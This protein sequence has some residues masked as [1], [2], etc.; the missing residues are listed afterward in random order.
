MSDDNH[1]FNPVRPISNL[2]DD[3]L[4][5]RGFAEAISKSLLGWTG[6]DSLVLAICGRW[7][8]GKTSVKNMVL[9][10]IPADASRKPEV[11][12]FN[13]WQWAGQDQVFD[14]FFAAVEDGLRRA[15]P[16][17]V[18]KKR[19]R[20]WNSRA[21]FYRAVRG[22]SVGVR[23]ILLAILSLILFAAAVVSSFVPEA[24]NVATW[25]FRIGSFIFAPIIF[26]ERILSGLADIAENLHKGWGPKVRSVFERRD[27]KKQ[28]LA[29]SLSNLERPILVVIDDIDR[30]T[31]EQIRMVF[32]LVKANADF[33]SLI[34]LLLFQRDIVEKSLREDG[35]VSG[36][37]YLEKIAQVLIDLPMI[38]RARVE[39]IL[40]KRLDVV[41]GFPEAQKRFD[42]L[43][44][45]DMFLSGVRPYFRNLRDVY[46]FLSTL[47]FHLSVFRREGRLDINVLDLVGVEVLRLFEPSVY[48]LMA[49]SKAT[50]TS[51]HEDIMMTVDSKKYDEAV[52]E[53][54]IESATKGHEDDV[55]GLLRVL[56][57][58]CEPIATL[59]ASIDDEWAR[60]LRVAHPDI[61]DRYFLFAIPAGDVSEDEVGGLL[62]KVS[63]RNEFVTEFLRFKERGL[64]K[65]LLRR[66]DDYKASIGLQHAGSFVPAMFDIST[67][68]DAKADAGTFDVRATS[69]VSR[70]IYWYLLEEQNVKKREEI[71]R[72]A[73]KSS[74]ALYMPALLIM[75]E[76][77]R[78]EEGGTGEPLVSDGS[79]DRFKEL[80]VTMIREAAQEGKLIDIPELSFLLYW[81]AKWASFEEP[82]GYI[83]HEFEDP[84]KILRFLVA[85]LSSGSSSNEGKFYQ[86]RSESI[87]EFSS[88]D[89]LSKLL[90]NVD[91]KDLSQEERIA[92]LAFERSMRWEHGEPDE[93]M[94]KRHFAD[95]K[96]YVYANE[97]D[98]EGRLKSE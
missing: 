31:P 1:I 39:D 11:V 6:K 14:A 70:I 79:L 71:L 5:R 90:K 86:I 16:S 91:Q 42:Q 81:W 21:Q 18:G 27:D 57:P 89:T 69:Y 46:R 64:E 95:E 60:D 67:H 4:G 76:S 25:L 13:P 7:G 9:D 49:T 2:E 80:C 97:F 55:R 72:S 26:L 32:Q 83:E 54:L 93:V 82:R 66:L 45:S 41:L 24:N 28:Q 3:L 96:H 51:R 59:G 35:V 85:L 48:R 38:E 50:L 52:V 61:F 36:Q 94:K 56:F 33:P 75:R 20:D 88:F 19:A 30:L 40:F 12:E 68:L 29:T 15:D 43:R 47:E 87:K 34:Y 8:D 22:V 63:M 73:M 78:R 58:A 92:L 77:R 44:W 53:K 17:V 23:Q 62:S 74:E 65:A 98:S 84:Q 10:A 37:D